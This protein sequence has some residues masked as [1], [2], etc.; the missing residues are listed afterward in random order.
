MWCVKCRTLRWQKVEHVAAGIEK[1]L[2]S[3]KSTMD[4]EV[5]YMIAGYYLMSIFFIFMGGLPIK[6]PFIWRAPR[7]VAIGSYLYRFVESYTGKAI[8]RLSPFLSERDRAKFATVWRGNFSYTVYF[9]GYTDSFF[10]ESDLLSSEQRQA[11]SFYCTL[12]ALSFLGA[13][14]MFSIAVFFR[15]L[16][17]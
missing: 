9:F 10:R 2:R 11:R 6:P 13:S 1:E 17:L 15:L 12:A 4:P 5:P 7:G 16:N 8:A 14:L 3:R